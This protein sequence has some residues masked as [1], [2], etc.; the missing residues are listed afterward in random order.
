[1]RSL[2]G[3]LLY[4]VIQAPMAGV[5]S[6]RLTV[7]VCRAGALGSLPAAMLSPAQLAQ[8]LQA[9]RAAVG[10]RPYNVNF[11]AHAPV[12]AHADVL[13]AWRAR[14]QPYY[15]EF[16]A[17]D[18]AA[19]AAVRRPFDAEMLAVLQ[20]FRPPVVS[21]HFGL[22]AP[23]LLA[24]VRATGA[25]ILASATT[26]AEARFLQQ[27]G[28]DA[29][30]AQGWEAGGHR[31]WFLD[32]NPHGQ[33]GTFALL[34]N[35]VRAVSL[36]VIAAGGI[37]DAATARAALSLGAAAVQAGTAFLLADEADTAPAHRA[38]LQ[39]PAAGHTA[40]TNL[41]SGGGARGVVGRLMRELGVWHE[42]A[43]PFPHAAAALAPLRRAAEA[44]NEWGFSPFWAGQNAPLAQAGTAAQIVARLAG[45]AG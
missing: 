18:D 5:Q 28:A 12:V 45:K 7:A 36:P 43:P 33:S 14:L 10:S 40:V 39:S 31:G 19:P 35:I 1:M 37:A 30:I 17:A 41:F 29:V 11:F 20:Q 34:P 23:D 44:R 22:P 2:L 24:A 4:P 27:R 25:R 26:V 42:H 21:F 15:D 9:V 8:S 16:A 38:V 32:A 6:Q 13:A 3:Q